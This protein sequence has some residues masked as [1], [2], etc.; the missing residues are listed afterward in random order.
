[1][2]RRRACSLVQQTALLRASAMPLTCGTPR[3]SRARR[4]NCTVTPC[5]TV[6]HLAD[7][8]QRPTRLTFHRSLARVPPANWPSHSPRSRRH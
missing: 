8:A 7:P 4:Q 3:Q 5:R 1:M 6:R 2:R